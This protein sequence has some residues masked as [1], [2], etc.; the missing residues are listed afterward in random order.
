MRQG[1]INVTGM[2]LQFQ[3]CALPNIAKIMS[4]GVLHKNIIF[5][6]IRPALV[7]S[8]EFS[9]FVVLSSLFPLVVEVKY[10]RIRIRIEI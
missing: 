10:F 6:Q 9:A 7:I 2:Q 5:C 3:V 8:R 1:E 4:D